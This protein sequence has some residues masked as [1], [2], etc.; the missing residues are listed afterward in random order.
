MSLK[1]IARGFALALAASFSVAC[2]DGPV[3]PQVSPTA[4]VTVDASA[5]TAYIAF[6]NNTAN[7][8]TVADPAASN[9]WDLSFLVTAVAP[10]ANAGVLVHCLCANASAS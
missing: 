4:T 3:E 9:A 6:A 2:G 7:L 5:S 1:S 8:V 10:N